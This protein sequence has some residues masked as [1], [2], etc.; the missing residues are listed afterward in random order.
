MNLV[1]ICQCFYGIRFYFRHKN[2]RHKIF[3]WL[4]GFDSFNLISNDLILRVI[5]NK[6]PILGMRMLTWW[7]S[8]LRK[9]FIRRFYFIYLGCNRQTNLHIFKIIMCREHPLFRYQLKPWHFPT[10]DICN[11]NNM[12]FWHPNFFGSMSIST[13]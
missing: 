13:P 1:I 4:S 7:F 6:F 10:K 12:R 9:D 11:K 3:E 2:A 8:K 5:V